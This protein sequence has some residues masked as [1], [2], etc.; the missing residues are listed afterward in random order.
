MVFLTTIRTMSKRIKSSNDLFP[1][2]L[3]QVVLNGLLP[4]SALLTLRLVSKDARE[5]VKSS[6]ISWVTD[7]E[8][9][10]KLAKLDILRIIFPNALDIDARL[11]DFQRN[12]PHFYA[13]L[14]RMR[15][16]LDVDFSPCVHSLW[17]AVSLLPYCAHVECL[18][19][20]SVPA[21]FADPLFLVP[22][23]KLRSLN[24]SGS[25]FL[26]G[27]HLP[28]TL[29][30]IDMTYTEGLSVLPNSLHIVEASRSDLSMIPTHCRHFVGDRRNK[31]DFKLVRAPLISLQI[32][33]LLSPMIGFAYRAAATLVFLEISDNKSNLVLPSTPMPNLKTFLAENV[34]HLRHLPIAPHLEVLNINGSNY[35]DR[36][37]HQIVQLKLQLKIFIM[38]HT[39]L[40]NSISCPCFSDLGRVFSNLEWF[41]YDLAHIHGPALKK[42]LDILRIMQRVCPSVRCFTEMPLSPFFD[43][44]VETCSVVVN[45]PD[46]EFPLADAVDHVA[47]FA[48]S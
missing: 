12:A 33:R 38:I 47:F 7:R 25:K 21:L 4:L 28:L 13:T 43:F 46:E 36:I 30:E 40:S 11:S 1:I 23:T 29:T 32:A 3:E 48:L 39:T 31:I 5:N 22:L 26:N 17:P 27:L 20:G 45:G 10:G 37:L 18:D 44:R 24:I 9:S 2:V 6:P 15:L 41:G 19:L 14:K 8:Y 16:R 35:L 42:I 34:P